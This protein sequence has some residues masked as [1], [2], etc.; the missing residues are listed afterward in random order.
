MGQLFHTRRNRVNNKTT[1]RAFDINKVQQNIEEAMAEE[2]PRV[3]QP[4]ANRIT[5]FAPPAIR[6]AAAPPRSLTFAEIKEAG[7]I[8]AT[9]MA[10]QYLSAAAAIEQTGREYK[11]S[12]NALAAKLIDMARHIEEDGNYVMEEYVKA[13]DEYRARA[14]ALSAD[15]ELAMGKSEKAVELCHDLLAVL[16]ATESLK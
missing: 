11:A 15:I 9:T 10:N 8:A 12:Q 13:A 6:A 5:D 3:T 1:E 2:A 7:K 4:P 14:S 16:A